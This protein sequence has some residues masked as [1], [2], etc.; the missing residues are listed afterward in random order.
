MTNVDRS[1]SPGAPD[2][3]GKTEDTA[4]AVYLLRE[5]RSALG[6]DYGISVTLPASYWYLRWF[7]PKA[8][9]DSVDFFGLMT[10]DLH[11]PVSHFQYPFRLQY[12]ADTLIV[13]SGMRM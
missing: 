3:A 4:N 5:I 11:G 9:Q 2:R 12:C 6:S 13:Y 7:D 10:Y 8:M 1:C